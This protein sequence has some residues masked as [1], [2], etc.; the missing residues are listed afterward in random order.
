MNSDTTGSRLLAADTTAQLRFASWSPD[1]NKIAFYSRRAQDAAILEKYHMPYEHLLYVMEADGSHQERLFDFPVIDFA[2]APDSRRMMIISAYES[3]D[4]DS[5]EV[6]NATRNPLAYV[7]VIDLPA[8]GQTR[9]EG[10]GRNCSA[11]WSPDGDNL[12]VSFG[13]PENGGLYVMSADGRQKR[14][15]TDDS[16]IDSRPKWSPD[17]KSL[18]YAAYAKTAAGA[19]DAGVYVIAAD[20]SGKRRVAEDEVYYVRWS[21]D[22]GLL[23]LQ[24]GNRFRLVDPAGTR[25]RD[26][27]AGLRR[28]VNAIFSPDGTAVLYCSDDQGAWNIYSIGLDGQNRKKLTGRTNSSNFCLSP[29]LADR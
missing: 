3:P 24:G 26:L 27:S 21:G 20:G 1:G 23:L 14:S 17:G 9:L 6:L 22:G 12:A 2:W 5:V 4:R 25:Q 29:L 18:A 11:S 28:A 16:T 7:Y 8:G 15:L 13:D 10:S 19:V